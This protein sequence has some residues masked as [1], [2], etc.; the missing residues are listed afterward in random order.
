MKI[1]LIDTETT[2]LEATDVVIEVA[3]ALYD[4]THATVISTFSSLI[5]H[6]K[7]PAEKVN[8]IPAELLREAPEGTQVWPGVKRWMDRSDVLVAHNAGFDRFYVEK[9]VKSEK[10]W[11]CSMD[12]IEWPKRGRGRGLVDIALNHDLGIS[13][14]H[15]ADADVSILARLFSRTKE[16]GVDLDA[17]LKRAMLPRVRIVVKDRANRALN[18]IASDHGFRFE[19]ERREWSLYIR[20]GDP[21]NFPFEVEACP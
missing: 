8:R 12:D 17:L 6:D 21:M 5:R 14:V 1:L 9:C 11:V 10:Q 15:R 4:T 18:P 16:L 19:R 3:C 20:E 7:N 2:G 13:H